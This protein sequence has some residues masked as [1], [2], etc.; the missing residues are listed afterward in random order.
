MNGRWYVKPVR[1]EEYRQ[2]RMSEASIDIGAVERAGERLTHAVLLA[3]PA[4]E[5][6]VHLTS[7]F[8]RHAEAAVAQTGGDILRRTAESSD[9]KVVNRGGAIHRDVADDA[10]SHEIDEE[11]REPGL[12]NVAAEHNEDAALAAR[13][14]GNRIDDTEEVTS[15]EHVGQRG[16]KGAESAIIARRVRE[17]LSTH[18]IWPPRDG[19]GPD[20]VE[21]RFAR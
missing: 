4:D 14:A 11:R 8:L 6:L 20:G 1:A 21:I 15:D 18:L 2:F 5:G 10:A 9:F 17:L 12:Y 13:G 19:D 7:G 16:E 3:R